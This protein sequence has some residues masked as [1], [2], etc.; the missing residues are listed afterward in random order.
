MKNMEY[1]IICNDVVVAYAESQKL[2]T[3][4]LKG[5]F[6]N[7]DNVVRACILKVDNNE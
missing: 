2:A 7:Y 6:E 4:I 3:V 5:I 1:A